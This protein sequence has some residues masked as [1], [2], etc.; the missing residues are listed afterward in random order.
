MGKKKKRATVVR[1]SGKGARKND[2]SA[3][4]SSAALTPPQR[5]LSGGSYIQGLQNIGNTCYCNSL[6][7]SI[8]AVSLSETNV[9]TLLSGK[10][11]KALHDVMQVVNFEYPIALN[12]I[13]HLITLIP[14]SRFLGCNRDLVQ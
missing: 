9:S 7:Q 6:L 5:G 1:G 11:S 10:L 8:A 13:C 12:Q 3:W 4:E 14:H 2:Y